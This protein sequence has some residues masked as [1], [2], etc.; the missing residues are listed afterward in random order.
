MREDIIMEPGDKVKFRDV[1]IGEFFYDGTM[2]WESVRS[3]DVYSGSNEPDM[4]VMRAY[5]KVPG[6]VSDYPEGGLAED[7][8]NATFFY[9]GPKGFVDEFLKLVQ[10][11]VDKKNADITG[12]QEDEREV[13]SRKAT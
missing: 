3:G 11:D 5:R 4:A 2:V 7:Y 1:P 13:E 8:F 6:E 12:R 10:E 9:L